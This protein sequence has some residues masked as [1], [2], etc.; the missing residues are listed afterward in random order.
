MKARAS[1]QDM[2]TGSP[3]RLIVSFSLPLLIGNLFQQLYNIVDSIVV[4][5]FVNSA[6]LAAVGLGGGLT[7]LVISFF[8]GLSNGI[9]ILISQ[10]YGAEDHDNLKMAIETANTAMVYIAVPLTAVAILAT[11]ALLRLMGTNDETFGMA[12]EY[13]VVCFAAILPNLGYNMNS[14]IL[15]G[16]GDSR[17]PMKFLIVSTAVNIVLDLLFVGPL[18][19]GAMGAALAT[20]LAQCVGFVYSMIY[21]HRYC[22]SMGV[23]WFNPRLSLGLLGKML[24]LGVPIGV[25]MC[26]MSIG[27]MA[28]QSLVNRQPTAFMAGYSSAS[29]VDAFAFL[30]MMSFSTAVT[31]F[32]GQNIGAGKMDRVKSAVRSST[33]MS[34]IVSLVVGFAV[35]FAGP[36]IL[37]LFTRDAAVIDA[38]MIYL[39]QMMP[40]YWVLSIMFM[41]NGFMNGAGAVLV[42]TLGN[43]LNIW[44]GRV[45]SAYLLNHF[46]GASKM[47]YCFVIGWTL[48]A[49]ISL[50]YYLSGRWKNKAVVQ[51]AAE[52]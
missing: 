9:T 1:Y 2:T 42:P 34:V 26:L 27:Q 32:A 29:R 3:L 46:F 47:Y 48:G 28:L 7:W 12:Y 43:L 50:V 13:T 37:R 25:N 40:F 22:R 18:H 38:G 24:R 16:L 15:R 30:P 51:K 14:G 23:R 5:N 39:R 20:A 4:G 10:L 11:P 41:L 44:L 52:S 35:M 6:A 45:P 33:I 36:W 17:A 49:A 8:I 31:T 19:M 21:L